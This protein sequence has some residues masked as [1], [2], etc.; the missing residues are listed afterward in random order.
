MG[1]FLL[2]KVFI[3]IKDLL[4]MECILIELWQ[5]RSDPHLKLHP[6]A[7]FA[8]YSLSYSLAARVQD[9]SR[10][11]S[12]TKVETKRNLQQFIASV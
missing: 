8:F 1:H 4:V 11:K 6:I 12:P 5:S 3:F 10:P 9:N 2:Q 7:I